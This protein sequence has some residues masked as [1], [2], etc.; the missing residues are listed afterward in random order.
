MVVFNFFFGRLSSWVKIRFC[1]KNQLPRLPGSAVKVPRWWV[2]WVRV[3]GGV[4]GAE[5]EKVQKCLN[6]DFC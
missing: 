6:A 2:G 5:L 1:N 3:M 4:G